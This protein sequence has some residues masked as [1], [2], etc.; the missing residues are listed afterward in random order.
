MSQTFH[1][2]FSHAAQQAA[3]GAA[4]LV[5]AGCAG[6]GL[7]AGQQASA[8]SA[9]G[10]VAGTANPGAPPPAGGSA[11]PAAAPVAAETQPSPHRATAAAAAHARISGE[12]ADALPSVDLSSQILFQ[13]LAAEVAVQRGQTGSATVTYLSLAKQTKDPRLA[14]RATE[15]ALAE[16][17]LDRALQGAAMWQEFA[18]HSALAAQTLEALRISTGRLTDAEPLIAARRDKARADGALPGFYKELQRTLQRAPDKTAALELY[19]R[20]SEPDAQL[21]EARLGAAA[22]AAA[23]G[24]AERAALE[25]EQAFA[26]KPDDET[27]A[28]NA[29]RFIADGPKGKAGSLA[30]LAE[31]L[32]R[33]PRST[34]TRFAYARLLAE[35]G[36][37]AAARREM[38]LALSDEPESPP[39]LFS[40]AQIAYQTKQLDV[41]QDYLKRFLALAPGIPRDNAPAYLFLGQIAEEQ[42]RLEDAIDWFAKVTRGEQLTTAVVRRALLLGKL[43]R[44][45]AARELLRGTSVPSTRE[46][47]QLIA[48]EA[49]LLRDRKRPAEAFEVLEKALESLPDNPELLYDHAMA[50][51]RLDQVEVMERSLRRLIELR[52]DNAHAYNALGYS[53]A[54]RGLRLEEAQTLIEKALK[55]LPDDAHI[56]DSL[57]WVLYRRGRSEEAL[58]PLRRA[59][60]MRP[61]AEVAAHLGEVLWKLGRTAEARN[62][63]RDARSKEP[64]NEILRETLARLNVSF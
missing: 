58:V 31:F 38:E 27:I 39:I 15:L 61:E 50:A 24:N 40:L 49:Q 59:F 18:P 48:A 23:A 33:V 2:L 52:P 62:I 26:L 10:V 7:G 43:D 16:R 47:V 28:V 12:D 5:L 29:A 4:T 19:S 51:E 11:A 46:R 37:P 8:A 41:A 1:R 55:I 30:L 60:E 36:D 34:E 25:A 45:D 54:D 64:E 3:L 9:S 6:L 14:R 56:L 13:L 42:N 32:K 20:L 63:W 44:V 35:T 22:L 57:G 17:S 53:L 21:A